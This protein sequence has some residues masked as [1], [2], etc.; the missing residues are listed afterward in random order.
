MALVQHS[1]P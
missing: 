1:R